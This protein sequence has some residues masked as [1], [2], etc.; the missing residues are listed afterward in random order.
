MGDTSIIARRLA[1]K[2]VQYGWSGNGG[3]FSSVG[4][5]I[6]EW[7]TQ[8]EMVEY[9]FGLGQLRHLWAPHS[10]EG[11]FWFR[12]IPD[13]Q[14]HW[15]GE[16]ERAIFSKIAFVDYGYFYDSDNTW[17]YI[18]PGPFRIKIPLALV[19]E[20]LDEKGLEFDF[21]DRVVMQIMEKVFDLCRHDPMIRES[22]VGTDYSDE[23]AIR[24]MEEEVMADRYPLRAFW[25]HYR[26]VFNCFDD[27][28]LIKAD[29]SGT[30][31]KEILLKPK[32]EP[33]VETIH[34]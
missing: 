30:K 29:E 1:D 5:S 25:E 27:W 20:N 17:Y 3:D 9:L 15:V 24:T 13:E 14:P 33:H 31:V 28:V 22:L 23:A 21:R 12:T 32:E 19:G 6:L 8:P 2:R 26:P 11:T 7:Y 4:S 18:V 10:E 16:T 34:W